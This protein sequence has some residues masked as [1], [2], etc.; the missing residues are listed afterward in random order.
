VVDELFNPARL[1]FDLLLKALGLLL[2]VHAWGFV[3]FLVRSWLVRRT[4]ESPELSA[5]V[6]ASFQ[7]HF[8]SMH[9]GVGSVYG[10]IAA[11]ATVES[12]L[13]SG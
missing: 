6:R 11:A 1:S 7:N 5:Y 12:L 3:L 13:N 2:G 8:D 4:I 10:W 9:R